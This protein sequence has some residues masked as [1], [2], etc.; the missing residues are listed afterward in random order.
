MLQY[1]MVMFVSR[2]EEFETLFNGR[3]PEML[4]FTGLKEKHF[5][6]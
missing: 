6:K 3:L 2:T 4:D 1:L 5:L